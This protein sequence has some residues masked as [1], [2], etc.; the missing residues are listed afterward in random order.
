MDKPLGTYSFLPYLRV[1]LANKILQPDQDPVKLRASFHLELKLDGKA[2]EGGGTLSET[3]ARDVQLYG[4]GD[5]VGIDPRAIIKTEPRNW[6]TN[7][8]PNYLPYIDFYDEDFPWR[9]TPSKADEPAHR[10][11]PWLALV[12]LEEGEFED[13]K[14]LIDKPLPF[15]HV[16]NAAAKFPPAAQLWAWAHIHVNRDLGAQED[17]IVSENM[18]AVLPKLDSALK[19]NPDLAYSRIV[20]PR[21]LKPSAGYHAFL[22]PAYEG[23]RQAGLGMDVDPDFASQ[24]AWGEAGQLDFPY[25][26]RWYFRTS[27]VG[28]FEYLVRLLEAKPADERV[29]RRDMDVQ[30]PGWNLSG[31]DP[32]GLLGGILK[33]GGAL[34]VPDEVISDLDEFYKYE[35]W[36]KNDYPQPVNEDIAQFINLADDYQKPGANPQPIPDPENPLDPDPLI[37]PPLYGRWHAAVDRMLTKADGTPQP[38]SKNWIHEL[39]LDPR[40]RVPAGFGTKVIQEKQEEYMNAAWEQVGDVVKANHFIRFA[41]LSAEALFQW[42]SK[43]IQPLSLQAPDTLLMLSAPVQK[44]LLVQN[45][46]VFHQLKMGVVPPVAVSAQLRKITRPRSRA[47]VKLPFEKN[48]VQPVQMIGRLNSGEI[49]AAPPKVTPPA[50]RTEEVLNEQTTPQPKP[51]WLA[52]LLRKYNWLPM[53]T[54]ALAVLLLILLLLFMPSGFLMVLGL[55]AVGGLAYLYVRMNAILRA[56]AQ[57]PV[58]EESAQTPEQVERAPKSPD[59]RIVEPED[60]FR[61]A[62]GGTDSAEATRF[63]V[64]LKELY[65]VDIAARDAA[66]EPPKQTLDLPL[67]AAQTAI[68]LHPDKTVPKLLLDRIFLP[69]RFRIRFVPELFDQIMEYPKFDIP[70]YE[71]LVKLSDEYFL[72][73]I[74][75]IEQNSITLL[76][77][78]QKFIESYMV[79]INH[80]MS[81]ELLWREYPTDQRGSYFRQFWDVSAYLPEEGEDQDPEALKEKLKDIPELHKWR[82][83]SELGDHDNRETGGTKEEEVVLVIRG[84]LLK[85][86]PNAVIY[87]HKAKWQLKDNGDIDNQ[88]ERDLADIPE[89]MEDNPPHDIVKMPLYS[90]KVD[91]DI[92]FFGF[93]LTSEVAKGGDGTKPEDKDNPGWF[94]GIK[95]RPGEARFGLD[96]GGPNVVKHTWNDLAWED[97][98]PGLP[99][100]GFLEITNATP[101]IGLTKPTDTTQAEYDEE[102]AQYEDDKHVAWNKDVDASDLAYILY[103]VPVMVAV[104]ASE[105]LKPKGT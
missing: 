25:Y 72:P 89:G 29:G 47:V 96:T 62:S 32:D 21:K 11:R 102:L 22:I 71:P 40:F 8:E 7:F 10:L 98:A 4:P 82:L 41:Q 45:T 86:Y 39:N 36:L 19:E 2:V 95:E 91:P 9:Y 78:N 50:I 68:N 99:E 6:I 20:C 60:R 67:I 83:T 101:A 92:Y 33:L 75:L 23:G 35:D 27:T 43:Q 76:E 3:I 26:H 51:E 59:F 28:D 46:T 15:I 84:E 77:T 105:M 52:D 103:Q 79:G 70:M 56:L 57:P 65:A 13:G 88:K 104:H 17:E 81:R 31:L 64:A 37:T 53:L 97:A 69:D 58:F 44:R 74:N 12:V 38:N 80:E 34:R 55:A 61:P 85:K 94:F 18:G 54:L 90:A 42:H 24:Y 1:G 100:N 14:N 87:A 30:Q 73:N 66:F 16:E 5:I 48:N 63:K 93:D 49:V